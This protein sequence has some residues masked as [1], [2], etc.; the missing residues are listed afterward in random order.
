[1]HW[2]LLPL[3]QDDE[4]KAGERTAARQHSLLKIP[5]PSR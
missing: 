4:A 1:M 5:R 2:H 3:G